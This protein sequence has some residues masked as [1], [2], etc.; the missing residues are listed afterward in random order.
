MGEA[1]LEAE[2]RALFD[3]ADGDPHA[4]VAEMVDAFSAF[5]LADVPVREPRSGLR[6]EVMAAAT[7]V[8][9]RGRPAPAAGV[10]SF[11]RSARLPWTLAAGFA[12]A[13][14]LALLSW[15]AERSRAGRLEGEVARLAERAEASD[16]RVRELASQV[17]QSF[18]A[19]IVWDDS[20]GTGVLKVENLPALGEGGDYQLWVVSEGYENPLDGGV[21]DTEGGK[22]EMRIVTRDTSS[23]PASAGG[24]TLFAISRERE[25]GV[26]ISET[27]D[28]VLTAAY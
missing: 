12:L 23:A 4:E 10:A 2:V 15:D 27:K 7:G 22:A 25:G 1:A 21:F 16:L 18:K 26:P 17:D 8:G 13:A 20:R 24:V 3:C 9:V 5:A 28:F 6:A 11:A 19:F 14:G